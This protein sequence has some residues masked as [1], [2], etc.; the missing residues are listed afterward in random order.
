[1]SNAARWWMGLNNP[2]LPIEDIQIGILGVPYD[3][4]VSLDIG[5]AEAPFV[6]RELSAMGEPYTDTLIDLRSMRVKD[7]GDVVVDNHNAERT[8]LA[9]TTAVS[10]LVNA[11]VL[12]L[13]I[14]G[15]H[16]ITS[17]S[18]KA[19]SQVSNLGVIWFDSHPDLMDVYQGNARTGAGQWNHACPLRRIIE[20][21]CVNKDYVMLLGIRDIMEEEYH[22]AQEHGIEIIT[23]DELLSISLKDLADRIGKKFAGAGGVY[24]SIDIDVLDPACAPGTGVPVPGGVSTRYMLSFLREIT[25]R[26]RL[27]IKEGKHY[28]GLIGADIVEVAPPLDIRNMTSLT[29]IS[30]LK[31]I[32]A[33]LTV[34]MEE[35]RI[36]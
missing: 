25:E 17:A 27:A 29:A 2:E 14:G 12:P 20:L 6:M 9:V 3:G 24:M 26:E 4:S 19:F 8:Q 28:I 36:K 33:F 5:A 16:S 21:S 23:A 1:M 7:F 30:I 22:F 18:V 34:Q 10:G 35:G 15:D 11:G 31:G 32:L 13:I